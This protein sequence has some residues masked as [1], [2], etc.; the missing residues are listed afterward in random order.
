MLC[1]ILQVVVILFITSHYLQQMFTTHD[2]LNSNTSQIHKKHRVQKI[3][4]QITYMICY[5]NM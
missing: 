5:K 3:K 1:C 4:F 2:V